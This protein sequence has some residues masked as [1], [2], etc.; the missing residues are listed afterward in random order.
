VDLALVLEPV[1]EHRNVVHGEI[2]TRRGR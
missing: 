2:N 1:G